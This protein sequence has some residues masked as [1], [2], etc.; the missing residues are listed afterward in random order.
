[1]I[2]QEHIENI[3]EQLSDPMKF[4]QASRDFIERQPAFIAYLNSEGFSLL[5]EE[6][7]DLLWYCTIVIYECMKQDRNIR[8]I[9]IE[10]IEEAEEINYSI[11]GEKELKFEEIVDRLFNAYGQEDLLAFAEDATMMDEEDFLSPVG[12]K[13]IFISLKTIIDVIDHIKSDIVIKN[14]G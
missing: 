11:L 7:K 12:R 9:S 1:M 2:G 3:I 6:E 4:M 13:I 14:R 5:T 10:A 8:E